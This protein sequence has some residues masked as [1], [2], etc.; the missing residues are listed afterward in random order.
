MLLS[1]SRKFVLLSKESSPKMWRV[2]FTF[3][4][5][6][7]KTF[8]SKLSRS[9]K[10]DHVL[11]MWASTESICVILNIEW[12]STVHQICQTSWLTRVFDLN[13]LVTI[14]YVTLHWLQYY[15]VIWYA[16][17]KCAVIPVTVCHI[18]CICFGKGPLFLS[19]RFDSDFAFHSI[20]A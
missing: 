5:C 6:N 8:L 17:H 7:V 15:V 3:F 12:R 9:I 1:S 20:K 13:I 16:C 19:R 18:S 10:A 11:D 4:F 14:G 2:V